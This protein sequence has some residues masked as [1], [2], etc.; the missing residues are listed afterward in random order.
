MA[1]FVELRQGEVVR[2]ISLPRTPVNR[3]KKGERKGRGWCPTP[4]VYS[5][6]ETSSPPQGPKH[7]RNHSAGAGDGLPARS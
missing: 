7:L 5:L 3:G 2:R 1:N 6:S 4:Q